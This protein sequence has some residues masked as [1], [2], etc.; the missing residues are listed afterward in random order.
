MRR[1][2]GVLATLAVIGA[3]LT[4]CAAPEDDTWRV[5]VSP[6]GE[7]VLEVDGGPVVVIPAGSVS[8]RGTLVVTTTGEAPALPEAMAGTTPWSIHL[9]GAE[10][11]GPATLTFSLTETGDVGAVLAYYD[12]V[13]GEWLAEESAEVV[14]GER[15]TVQVTHFSWWNPF[16]WSWGKA[17]EWVSNGLSKIALANAQQPTCEGED[18]ARAA[19]SVTSDDGSR[20]KWC[21][22]V[23]G[24]QSVMRL[25]NNRPYAV[26]VAVPTGWTQHGV[27]SPR[28][29][30]W[31]GIAA[32]VSDGTLSSSYT[33][34]GASQTV[35]YRAG[36]GSGGDFR[37]QVDGLAQTVG[38]LAYAVQTLTMVTSFGPIGRS[39]SDDDL[40]RVTSDVVGKGGCLDSLHS[41]V[42]PDYGEFSKLT[43]G[44]GSV[45]DC[46]KTEWINAIGM[47]GFLAKA[48]ASI[49]GWVIGSFQSLIA[50]VT[51]LVD[52]FDFNGYVVRIQPKAMLISASGVGPVQLGGTFDAAAS[53]AAW[54]AA[55]RATGSC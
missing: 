23:E 8:A 29:G 46:M 19:V 42:D 30:L 7:T 52:T 13:S 48:F 55:E 26:T 50:N 6:D 34:L 49:L 53:G 33:V 41:M 24:G 11:I 18:A 36:L 28:L 5:S 32:F 47:S 20:V 21:L 15:V 17:R 54:T 2:M 39:L 14:D 9:E 1:F 27:P 44:I 25:A 22:G 16:S 51:A 31:D 40:L 10:L 43:G 37:V 45:A 4:A 3:L 12:D 38:V 35:T